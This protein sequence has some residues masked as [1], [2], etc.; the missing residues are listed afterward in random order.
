MP[1]SLPQ[2]AV[3]YI[4]L[5]EYVRVCVCVCAGQVVF[6]VNKLSVVVGRKMWAKCEGQRKGY[7]MVSHF[8]LCEINFRRVNGLHN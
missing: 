1:D 5:L 2:E 4:A 8:S 6:I 3:Q 7:G